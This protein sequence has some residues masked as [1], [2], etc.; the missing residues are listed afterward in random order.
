MEEL[1]KLIENRVG[2]SEA[3]ARQAA[4]TAIEFVKGRLP[5]G[6]AGHVDDF[7]AGKGMPNTMSLMGSLFGRK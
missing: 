3:Q 7:V 6:L 5:S 1:V 4:E 2:I